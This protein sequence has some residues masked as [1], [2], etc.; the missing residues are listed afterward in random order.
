[1]VLDGVSSPTALPMREYLV[2]YAENIN[3]TRLSAALTRRRVA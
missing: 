3:A 1:M 2:G